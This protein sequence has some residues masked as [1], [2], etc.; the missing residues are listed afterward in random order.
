MNLLL[1]G[2]NTAIYAIGNI[3]FRAISFLLVPLYINSL[4]VADYGFLS[5]LLLTIQILVILMNLGIQSSIVRYTKE[6]EDINF[7]GQFLGASIL[8]NIASGMVITLVTLLILSPLLQ[9]LFADNISTY[10]LLTCAAALLQSLCLNIMSYYRAR[11]EAI[12]FV[13]ASIGLSLLIIIINLTI[14]LIYHM[15]IKGILAAYVTAYL[16]VFLC[17]YLSVLSDISLNLSFKILSKILKFG[18]P[19]VFARSGRFIMGASGVYFLGLFRGLEDVAIFSFGLKMA[20]VIEVLVVM[21]FFLAFPPFV[22]SHI[23][24]PE[25]KNTIARLLTYFVFAITFISFLSL[26]SFRILLPKIAP[27]DYSSAYFVLALLIPAIAFKGIS[28]FGEVFFHL[29]YTTKTVGQIIAFFALLCLVLNYA[30]IAEN[31]LYGAIF[32]I[33]ICYITS[34]LTIMMLGNK[35][36]PI[37]IEWRRLGISICLFV[38]CIILF[39]LLY[40][41]KD[42]SF[43]TISLIAAALAGIIVYMVIIRN[44]KDRAIAEKILQ[45]LTTR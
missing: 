26:F 19:L 28:F 2:K 44:D 1:L 45:V 3:S 10:L 39:L 37:P 33:N 8:L 25:I 7:S 21:P 20:Q 23:D 16:A 5:M 29:T 18:F 43:Y 13:L 17:M 31:G 27:N 35:F 41:F 42:I 38:C 40:K 36:F 15:G 24:K 34:G 32:V 14:V 11:N 12:K 6:F 9:H 4:S 30:I 22:F